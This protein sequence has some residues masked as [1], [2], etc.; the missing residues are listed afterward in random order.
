M[1]ITTPE[2]KPRYHDITFDNDGNIWQVT[3]NDSKSYAE[4]KPGLVQYDGKTGAVLMT[5]DFA[6]GSC[7]PHGLENHNG[8]LVSCDAGIHPGWPNSDSPSSGY[9]F[10]I[11]LV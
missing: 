6:P 5:V 2:D 3:G 1:P 4:G 9:I 8:T 7:D 11:D 10:R